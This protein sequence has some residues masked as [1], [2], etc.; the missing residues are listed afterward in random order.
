MTRVTRSPSFSMEVRDYVCTLSN[1]RYRKS[2]NLSRV[3]TK[4][5][6]AE[7]R[8]LGEDLSGVAVSA[9]RM[10]TRRC[11]HRPS[12]AGRQCIRDIIGL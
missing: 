7:L 10:E 11:N 2:A 6:K 9:R 4:C 3:T 12:V 5:I 1:Y 8:S